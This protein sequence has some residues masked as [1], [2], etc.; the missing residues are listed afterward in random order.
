MELRLIREP[1]VNGATH[2]S[3]YVDGHWQCWTLEDE[4]REVTGQPVTSWKVYG[5]T[6]IP[7]GRYRV[8]ITDSQRFGRPMPLLLSVQGFDGIRIHPGNVIADTDGCPL[9]GRE[10]RPGRVLQSRV[11]FEAL[12]ATLAAASGETWISVENPAAASEAA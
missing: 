8:V 6:A 7:A 9:V 11:A 10:R 3:L 5:H 1:S 2:G 12:F 4:L